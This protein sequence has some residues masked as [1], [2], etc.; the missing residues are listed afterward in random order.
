MKLLCKTVPALLLA[1]IFLFSAVSAHAQPLEQGTPVALSAPSCLLMEAGTGTVIFEKNADTPRPVASV[2]KLMTALLILEAIDAGK[3]SVDDPVT[4]SKN[5]AN[6]TGSTALLDAGAT[7]PLGDLLRAAVVASGNDS[8]VALAEHMAGTEQAFVQQMNERAAALG[9][10]NTVYVNCTGLPAEGQHTTAR[11]VAVIASA[12][13]AHPLY[14]ENSSLWLSKITHPSGRVTDLT[15]TNRLVRFYTDCDG[16][17]TG[18]TSEAKY[19]IAATAQRNGM[20]LIAVALGADTSQHRFD[21]AR[22]MLDYGFATYTRTQV[23][24]AG[25]LT[26]Y[27]IPVTRGAKDAVNVA[28]GKG[29]SMLLRP[30][31]AERLRVELVLPE[32]VTAP[33]SA[34]TAVGTARV[35]LDGAA[36]AEL[37]AVL[38]EDVRLPGYLEGFLRIR[39]QWR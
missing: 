12:V 1:G 39:D 22:A 36:V 30:G 35:L 9:L 3:L 27:Q 21:D 8:A 16:L 18:S 11:D 33:M 6:T 20:R 10:Q 29:L 7:Y 4:V 37:P 17:K 23:I 5:A 31:Q 34:G 28:V 38:A 24:A 25:D 26:G 14:F 32:S 2:T 19:C 13:C 15:N